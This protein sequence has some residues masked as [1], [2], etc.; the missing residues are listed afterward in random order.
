[1]RMNITTALGRTA[2]SKVAT[3]PNTAYM[4]RAY[5]LA[6]RDIALYA[7]NIISNSMMSG[8]LINFTAD[9][10]RQKNFGKAVLSIALVKA[11]EMHGFFDF[12]LWR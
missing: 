4:L 1:M 6:I 8:Q 9:I 11:K 7:G 5:S 12:E 2:G 3:S 10:N